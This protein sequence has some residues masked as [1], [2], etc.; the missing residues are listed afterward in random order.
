MSAEPLVM[1]EPEIQW[2]LP[3]RGRVGMYGL[4]AAEAAI[5][6][7]FV[8]AYLFYIGESVTG[9]TPREVLRV[10]IFF[11]ICLLSSSVTIHLAVKAL[12]GGNTRGFALRWILTIALGVAFL[13]GTVRE[14]RHLI[15]E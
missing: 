14:W 15:Y 10:P 1:P 8:V 3:P 11:T 9:P 5:F 2:K 4:I 13:A 7:I 12:S 6:T